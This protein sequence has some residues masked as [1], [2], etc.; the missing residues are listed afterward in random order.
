MTE[1]CSNEFKRRFQPSTR[2]FFASKY[3]G[4]CENG[5]LFL[6]WDFTLVS[7]SEKDICARLE[8]DI[9]CYSLKI[10][11]LSTGKLLIYISYVYNQYELAL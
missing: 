1:W 5:Y 2:F 3:N 10:V 9:L 4:P 6:W 7:L 11:E 8:F